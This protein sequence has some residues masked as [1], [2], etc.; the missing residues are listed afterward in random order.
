[1]RNMLIQLLCQIDCSVGLVFA[2]ATAE[3][4]VLGS[5]QKVLMG[6]SNTN[7]SVARSLEVGSM[8]PLS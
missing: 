5:I 6:F 4:G 7:F 1:M 2:S 3:P 8:I